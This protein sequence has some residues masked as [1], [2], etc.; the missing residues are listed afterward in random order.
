MRRL[1]AARTTA[2][3]ATSAHEATSVTTHQMRNPRV[4]GTSPSIPDHQRHACAPEG[5]LFGKKADRE[6]VDVSANASEITQLPAESRPVRQKAGRAAANVHGWQCLSHGKHV[7]EIVD[8]HVQQAEPADKVRSKRVG[9]PV[10]RNPDDDVSGERGDAA[11][12]NLMLIAMLEKTRHVAEVHL[13]PD[14]V[15]EQSAA[16][17]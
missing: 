1:S 13:D 11:L 5:E 4:I 3:E 6:R 2:P 9:G 15:S 12:R 10:P 17:A 7:I 16:D 8:V 14:D